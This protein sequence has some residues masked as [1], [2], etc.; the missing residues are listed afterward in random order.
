MLLRRSVLRFLPLIIAGSMCG[1]TS[2]QNSSRPPWS[3]SPRM[4]AAAREPSVPVSQGS[5]SQLA[6]LTVKGFTF[7][8]G[9]S[10][11]VSGE[12]VVAVQYPVRSKLAY[13]YQGNSSGWGNVLPVATLASPPSQER[14]NALVAIDRDT[15]VIGS[16]AFETGDGYVY[17]YVKPAGGWTNMFPTAI[18]TPSGV[19]DG[20]FGGSVSISGDTIVVGGTSYDTAANAYVFVKPAGGWT[21]MTETAKL[22]ASDELA[23]SEFAE[24]VAVSGNTIAVGAPGSDRSTGRAYVFVEPSGGWTNMT[25]TAKL[26][27]SDALAD[28]RVGNSISIDGDNI[29]VGAP[30]PGNTI[31]G[32][33]YIFSKPAAGWRNTTQTAELSAADGVA[34]NFFG[35]SVSISGQLAIVGAPFR[36]V[37]PDRAQG[38]IYVFQQPAGGWQDAS[39]STVLTASD[40]HHNADFGTALSISGK[41]V[42]GGSNYLLPN[43]AYVFGLP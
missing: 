2:A 23:T 6:K 28:A 7:S 17:V 40:V 35:G 36:G 5:W 30:N 39:S 12:T 41:T 15:I 32:V 31:P 22:T 43:A 13:V 16:P 21:N 8:L 14:F 29:L 19:N 1:I 11:A 27:A 38:G 37:A 4:A 18:L 3:L 24:S 26:G 9:E 33:A 34:F 20:F 10:V 25:E 42:V